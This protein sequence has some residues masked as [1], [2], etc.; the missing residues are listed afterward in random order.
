MMRPPLISE[1]GFWQF[2]DGNWIPTYKQLLGAGLTQEQIDDM[3]EVPVPTPPVN[4][5]SSVPVPALDMYPQKSPPLEKSKGKRIIAGLVSVFFVMII[6]VS[7]SRI[8]QGTI[9]LL[10]DNRDSDGDGIDDDYDLFP[11]DSTEYADNDGDGIGDNADT[12]DDNDGTL[13]VSDQFP[14]DSNESIDTDGDGIGNNA[15]TDD[16]NDG[17]ADNIDVNDFADT[18]LLFHF[19]SVK[20]IEKMD[21]FDNYAELY[22]CMSIN[23][24]SQGCIGDSWSII[25]GTEY[26]INQDILVDL[27]EEDSTHEVIISLWDQ[28]ISNDDLMDINPDEGYDSFV[29]TFDSSISN[30]N[31]IQFNASGE[32]DGAGWDGVLL[33]SMSPTNLITYGEKSYEWIYSDS[34]YYLDWNLDYSTYLQYKQLDHTV[35]SNSDYAR[36]STPDELYVMNLANELN[37]LALNEGYSSDLERAEFILSFVGAIPYQYDID[38]TGYAE[39]PKYPIEMLWE[40]AGDCEDASALYISLMESLEF[41]AALALLEIKSSNDEND[42]WV[43]HAF[44]VIYI[45]D[46]SGEGYQWNEGDKANIPFYIAEATGWYD[47]QSAIGQK[48]WDEE[49]NLYLYDVE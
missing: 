29:Y 35:S 6:V 25:T 12:D 48:W 2:V 37:E 21:Y 27:S 32:G 45:P 7:S 24:V 1:D 5:F 33:F 30:S 44:P 15:D 3:Q 42:D 13:D 9:G 18:S 31:I 23:G 19:S 49:Q 38:G 46:Y 8:P 28:D 16:D 36:F 20:P 34:T 26:Y 4:Q 39:Y 47:G 14:L 22:F 10:D 41:D 17:V 43:G 11:E 40:N